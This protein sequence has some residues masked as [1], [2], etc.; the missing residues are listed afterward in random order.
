MKRTKLIKYLNQHNC[1]FVKH[2]KKHDKF[3]NHITGKKTVIPRYPEI[4]DYLCELICKQ[5]G[6]PKPTAK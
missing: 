6:I 1:G 2:G 4:D 5:L 3:M